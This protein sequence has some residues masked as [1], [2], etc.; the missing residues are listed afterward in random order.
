MTNIRLAPSMAL[1]LAAFLAACGNSS[2]SGG[3]T[4]T[5]GGTGVGGIWTYTANAAA[6]DTATCFVT[7]AALS[8][9]QSSG[10]FTGTYTGHLSCTIPGN[11]V[12]TTVSG[13]VDSGTVSA[14]TVRFKLDSVVTNTG[15]ANTGFTTMSGTLVAKLFGDSLTGTWTATKS[16][17]G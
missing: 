4:G 1:V 13:R 3:P 9:A 7:G 2:N 12:S 15:T 8:L 6:G 11:T 14:Q 17:G 5:T 16:S 10:T